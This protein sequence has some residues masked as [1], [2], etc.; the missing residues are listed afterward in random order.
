[1]NIE[2]KQSDLRSNSKLKIVDVDVQKIEIVADRLQIGHDRGDSDGQVFGAGPAAQARVDDQDTQW[3]LPL[4]SV[5]G[6][7]AP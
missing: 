1:M 5:A 6:A 4:T 3:V 2:V 7:F